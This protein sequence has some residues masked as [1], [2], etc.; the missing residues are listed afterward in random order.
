MDRA[1]HGV[2]GSGFFRAVVKNNRITRRVDESLD[3]EFPS[4]YCPQIIKNNQ[5]LDLTEKTRGAWSK[6]QS[7]HSK[8]V[9][10]SIE[11]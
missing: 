2:V 6:F 5:I 10:A 1:T 8:K 3:I 7:R 11:L 4:N 9:W